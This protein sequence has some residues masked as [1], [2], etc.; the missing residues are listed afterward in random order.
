MLES[1]MDNN[2]ER[3][4]MVPVTIPKHTLTHIEQ[5]RHTFDF[6]VITKEKQQVHK[7]GLIS[8]N[9]EYYD[10]DDD[11]DFDYPEGGLEAWIVVFGCF[12][13]LIACFGLL[14]STG[15]MENYLENHQLQNESTSTIGWIFSLMNFICFA[16]CILS[17][18]YFDR[19][20]FKSPV[21][22]GSILLV[23]GLFA[24]ANSTKIWHFIL[25]FSIVCG[26]GNGILFSPLVSAPAHYFKR[27][28]GTA[29]ALATIGGS[30]GGGLFPL[31]LR[32][33]FEM[34]STSNPHYGFQ[35]GIR[36]LAFIDLALLIVCIFLG[37]ERLSYIDENDRK[38]N[39]RKWKYIIRVY[40]LQSFDIKAFRDLR[41]LYC[42]FGTCLGEFSLISVM[43]YY[44][45]YAMSQGVSQSDAYML[46][47]AINLTGILGRW[48]PGRLSDSFGRFNV[49]ISTLIILGVVMFTGW[50]PFGT[51]LNNL[52]I[53]SCL[54]GFFSGSI[55]SLLPVC[56]G[57][58]SKTE[59]FGRRYSTMYFC[60][61]VTMLIGVPISGAIIGNKT[62]DDYQHYKIFCGVTTL[63]SGVCFIFARYFAV[64]FQWRKF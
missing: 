3:G 45:S 24:T 28:R 17:G 61:G 52:Y 30:V 40:V 36:T 29:T 25:S 54:Y 27:K 4:N 6:D 49:A 7:K 42:V 10:D 51:N 9:S 23:G 39:E 19:N 60:V 2:G 56:C 34:E 1:P 26:F 44:S 20:G 31:M 47:M 35:W 43:T 8:N 46:I 33:F 15:I 59:E 37:K 41:Y 14:N 64:G 53:I 22:L 48:V 58:I 55:L 50:Y 18:T 57:Q 16:S 63:F 21:I 38:I 5:H 32:R 11:D 12:S 13:G 62:Y